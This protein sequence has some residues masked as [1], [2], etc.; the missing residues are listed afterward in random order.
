MYGETAKPVMEAPAS[1]MERHSAE[2]DRRRRWFDEQAETIISLA[3]DQTKAR[4]L[5]TQAQRD[6]PTP[7]RQLRKLGG[8]LYAAGLITYARLRALRY[9]PDEGKMLNPATS[10]KALPGPGENK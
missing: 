10:N 3:S 8:L 9:S 2:Q 7:E 4:R 5:W 6:E 1:A